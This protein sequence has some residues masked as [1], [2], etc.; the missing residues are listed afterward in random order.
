MVHEI[1]IIK[2]MVL[3]RNFSSVVL[4]MC[5]SLIAYDL[6]LYI[7]ITHSEHYPVTIKSLFASLPHS[8]SAIRYHYNRLLLEGYVIH[9]LD[10]KDKRIKYIEPTEKLIQSVVSYAKGS[11]SILE[12]SLI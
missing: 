5:D 3:L 9:K 12:V 7:V 10:N 1:P 2:K 8:Y 11:N 6:I 4:P